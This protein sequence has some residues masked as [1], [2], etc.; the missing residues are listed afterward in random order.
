MRAQATLPLLVG[1]GTLPPGG[2]RLPFAVALPPGLP[3]SMEWRHDS[4]RASIKYKVKV[5]V[6]QVGFMAK[7][8]K[9][10]ATFDVLPPPPPPAPPLRA[11]A[12]AEGRACFCGGGRGLVRLAADAPAGVVAAG[13][14]LP[15]VVRVRRR[16]A[17]AGLG[18]RLRVQSACGSCC[19]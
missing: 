7:D 12:E 14:V 11:A 4:M 6:D 10:S 8:F 2:H 19:V 16:P 17:R 1:P 9:A 15:L 5:L 3:A 18:G 13:S